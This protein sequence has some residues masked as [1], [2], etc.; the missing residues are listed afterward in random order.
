MSCALPPP[1][2][3]AGPLWRRMRQTP[4]RDMLR[5]RVTARLDWEASLARSGLPAPARE[6]VAQVVKRTKL[7]RL[8]KAQVCDELVAHF[9]DGLAAGETTEELLQNFGEI[10]QTAEL[11][12]RAKKRQR[13]LLWHGLKWAGRGLLALVAVYL[14]LTVWY[15]TDKVVIRT[16]YLAQ[17]NA[18]ALNTPEGE[19]A[20][21]IYREELMKLR[22]EAK[23]TGNHEP[24]NFA[25]VCT[26][27]GNHPV[28]FKTALN[29]PEKF[30]V[31]V[32]GN[33]EVVTP[34]S[35]QWKMIEQ[36]LDAHA[37]TLA[38]FRAAAQ[39]RELGV[40]YGY[41][42]HPEDAAFLPGGWEP[43]KS[44]PLNTPLSPHEARE[45]HVSEEAV[46]HVLFGSVSYLLAADLHRAIAADDVPL[47][48]ADSEALLGLAHQL[49]GADTNSEIGLGV[50]IY[51]AED[52][53]RFVLAALPQLFSKGRCPD[54][55]ALGKLAEL[56][57]EHPV[58]VSDF[59]YQRAI[60]LDFVQRHYTDDGHGGGHFIVSEGHGAERMLFSLVGTAFSVGTLSRGE[61]NAMFTDFYDQLERDAKTPMW[62]QIKTP[63]DNA[64]E[65]W[66]D[67][68]A[69][70][71]MRRVPFKLVS[72]FRRFTPREYTNLLQVSHASLQLGIAL[73]RHQLARGSFPARL[74][75]LVPAYLESL[76][77]DPITGGPLHYRLDDKGNPIV[78]SVGSDRIDDGGYA[79]EFNG[80]DDTSA[81]RW[82]NYC[83]NGEM[84]GEVHGD[85][86]LWPMHDRP[87]MKV[88]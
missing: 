11:I 32:E 31:H 3:E 41:G 87:L 75:D 26:A 10:R 44:P 25:A 38:A 12:R 1:N 43:V 64:C 61:M 15:A 54:A 57:K 81:I 78:Y 68:P 20:W 71:Q 16:D 36:G 83:H 63:T 18:T 47:V 37:Q 62:K 46:P 29:E 23:W 13:P 79:P 66:W 4:L 51:P 34:A 73:H 35:P 59:H 55:Q 2:E 82:Y 30:S 56:L 88:K 77:V 19:R 14:G 52:T 9:G 40:L 67:K 24:A 49:G 22:K 21:P 74:Q 8:E 58:P 50:L 7:W 28:R 65:Y 70:F 39:K 45:R 17:L 86:I 80:E 33:D 76:P 69:S 42:C 53:H 60:A 84:H 85:W 48:L 72:A 27:W 5:G 6:I